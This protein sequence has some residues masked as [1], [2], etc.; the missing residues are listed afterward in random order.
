VLYL[1]IGGPQTLAVFPDYAS[2]ALNFRE[3]PPVPNVS[4]PSAGEELFYQPE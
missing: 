2:I 4:M 3:N 1:V